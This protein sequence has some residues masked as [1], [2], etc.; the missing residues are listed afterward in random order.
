MKIH[1]FYYVILIASNFKAL[2]QKNEQISHIFIRDKLVF[3]NPANYQH[4]NISCVWKLKNGTELWSDSISLPIPQSAESSKDTGSCLNYSQTGI[5]YQLNGFPKKVFIYNTQNISKIDFKLRGMFYRINGIELAERYNQYVIKYNI[6]S[7][8][9]LPFLC[10]SQYSFCDENLNITRRIHHDDLINIMGSVTHSNFP[11]PD[12]VIQSAIDIY[13]KN[14]D[15]II[16]KTGPN[17][18]RYSIPIKLIA[19]MLMEKL[20]MVKSM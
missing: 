15:S 12:N 7:D 18:L 8:F 6:A 2:F 11:I 20:I 9:L 4:Y 17:S 5:C 13:H 19:W 3:I 1:I 10:F 16:S 14:K